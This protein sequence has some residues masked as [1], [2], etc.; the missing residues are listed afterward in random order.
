MAI[1][2]VRPQL[3]CI[4]LRNIFLLKID[5]RKSAFYDVNIKFT[6]TNNKNKKE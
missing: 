1:E 4:T 2:K 3:K 6:A 5:A